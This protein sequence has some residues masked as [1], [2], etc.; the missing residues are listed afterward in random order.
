MANSIGWRR[1]NTTLSVFLSRALGATWALWMAW[2]FFVAAGNQHPVFTSRHECGTDPAEIL[3]PGELLEES[4]LRFIVAAHCANARYLAD[5]RIA[6]R[7]GGAPIEV[8]TRRLSVAGAPHY[9]IV[10]VGG[11]AAP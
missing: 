4:T 10:S 3:R 6:L 9:V 7:Y 1:W 8:E 5:E 2:V 11:E